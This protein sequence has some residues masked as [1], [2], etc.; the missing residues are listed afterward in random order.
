VYYCCRKLNLDW[1]KTQYRLLG[2]DIVIKGEELGN[3]YIQVINSLG[4]EVSTLKTHKSKNFFEFAKRY[5]YMGEEIT[6]FP[7]SA[8][9]EDGKRYYKLA[10]LLLETERKG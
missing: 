6:H 1:K 8:L 5:F 7:I 2:D 4:V 3:L 10:N 9:K